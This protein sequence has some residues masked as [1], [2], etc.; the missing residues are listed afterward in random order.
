MGCHTATSYAVS[1]AT[2]V[3]GSFIIGC[4]M[5][6]YSGKSSEL[7]SGL[8][9]SFTDCY[10]SALFSAL[11]ADGILD[12]YAHYDLILNIVDGQISAAF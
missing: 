12:L 2:D 5:E 7:I 11:A 9:S 3:T 6:S 8:D 1:S 10:W 4:D